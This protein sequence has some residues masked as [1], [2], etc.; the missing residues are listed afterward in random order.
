MSA[1]YE[2]L[3]AEGES[4]SDL[5]VR[6]TAQFANRFWSTASPPAFTGPGEVSG[7]LFG[8]F[9][10]ECVV[11]RAFPSFSERM[12]NREAASRAF[13]RLLEVAKTDPETSDLDVI[14]WY[15]LRS[16]GGLLGPDVDFHNLHFHHPTDLALVAREESG[17]LLFEIYSR[18]HGAL[19]STQDHLW[20][21]VRIRPGNVITAPL[22]IVMKAKI[23]DEFYLRAYGIDG[24]PKEVGAPRIWDKAISRV[25]VR[26]DANPAQMKASVAKPPEPIGPPPIPRTPDR[27]LAR[28]EGEDEYE[29]ARE[30]AR[31]REKESAQSTDQL[32][33]V[34]AAIVSKEWFAA[35]QLTTVVPKSPRMKRGADNALLVP[36]DD[37]TRRSKVLRVVFSALVFAAAACCTFAVVRFARSG[38]SIPAWSGQTIAEQNLG[39]K[40][41]SE[42]DRYLLTWNRSSPFVKSARSGMLQIDDGG[43]HRDV[44]LGAAEISGG[45]IL[46]RP[47]SE[48]VSFRLNVRGQNGA[49]LS[50]SIRVLGT[51]SQE[52]TIDLSQSLDAKK[53][54]SPELAIQAQHT[55]PAVTKPTTRSIEAQTAVRKPALTA[56]ADPAP[57]PKVDEPAA[58]GKNKNT[59]TGIPVR[60]LE[61]SAPAEQAN[62]APVNQLAPV[63]K[64]AEPTNSAKQTVSPTISSP[65]NQHALE[66]LPEARPQTPASGPLYVPPQPLRQV[67][68]RTQYLAGGLLSA[69][70]RVEVVVQVDESGKVKQARLANPG[71]VNLA[72]AAVAVAAAKQW[73]FRP[74][75]LHGAKVPSEHVIVFQFQSPRQ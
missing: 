33:P 62:E 66:P 56:A 68:P 38:F 70:P 8:R 23:K 60:P 27:A 34:A 18:R 17:D 12:E 7:L 72:L 6:V 20:G 45:S 3:V 65:Q 13:P 28:P 43:Q 15:C 49:N 54:A 51:K 71:K 35:D 73:T 40:L 16:F 21:V 48:D 42:G 61:S 36:S 74:A 46:Y 39:M 11:V 41:E 29:A 14:G 4:A 67:M 55:I 63:D 47:S 30:I 58:T 64:A 59:E 5:R 50:E 26:R 10:A 1:V 44:Q 19:L 53:A 24:E 9:D 57:R 31:R 2:N 52:K 37:R 22:E 25:F 32:T 75:T 69:S